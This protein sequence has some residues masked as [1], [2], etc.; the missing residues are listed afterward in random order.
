MASTNPNKEPGFEA[1]DGQTKH[2]REGGDPQLGEMLRET[3]E[4]LRSFTE[5]SGEAYIELNDRGLITDWNARA[6]ETFGWE[7]DEVLGRSVFTNIIPERYRQP[8]DTGL[9][10]FLET[11]EVRF[12]KHRVEISALRRDRSEFPAELMLWATTNLGEVR[13]NALILDVTGR[14]TEE[15]IADEANRKL[16]VWVEE[17]ARRNSEID[18]LTETTEGLRV[19]SLRDPLTN[20]FN[21]RYMEESLDREIVR[22]ERGE[23]HLGVIMIDVDRFKE[24]NDTLGH[25][26]GD[27]VLRRLASYLQ[28]SIRGGDIACRYGGEEFILILPDAALDVTRERADRLRLAVKDNQLTFRGRSLPAPTLSLGVAVF[29]TDGQTR[30]SLLRAADAALYAAKSSGR[31]RVVAASELS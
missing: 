21:R 22:A 15:Q 9:A 10:H 30:D 26:G 16:Q 18:E 29:P 20:L 5:A 25:E 24:V 13:V 17:L 8:D 2:R 12:P 31:D 23:S 27:A 6:R 7:R 3:K 11:K 1:E 19:Q 28:S 14:M 4:R